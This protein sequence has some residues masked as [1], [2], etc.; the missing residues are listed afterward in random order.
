MA[1]I[2]LQSLLGQR[3]ADPFGR[4]EYVTVTGVDAVIQWIN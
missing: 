3:I 1:E 4:E 2:N